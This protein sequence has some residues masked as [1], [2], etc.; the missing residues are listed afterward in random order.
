MVDDGVNND[1]GSFVISNSSY[2]APD[3]RGTITTSRAKLGSSPVTHLG[4]AQS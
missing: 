1:P 2:S 4:T 3:G